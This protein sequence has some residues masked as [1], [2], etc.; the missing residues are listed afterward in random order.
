MKFLVA[1]LERKRLVEIEVAS[2]SCRRVFEAVLDDHDA[3]KQP[4]RFER[5][6]SCATF[7]AHINGATEYSFSPLDCLHQLHHTIDIEFPCFATRTSIP[8]RYID[9]YK[10]R[11]LC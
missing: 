4:N 3:P 11:I 7:Q 8:G 2:P 10:S 1:R 6:T 5:P 9:P